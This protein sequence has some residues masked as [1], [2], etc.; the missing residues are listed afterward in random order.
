MQKLLILFILPA[1]I[2][3]CTID[4]KKSVQETMIGIACGE[5]EGK[6]FHGYRL[7][8][9]GVSKFTT[10][11]LDDLDKAQWSKAMD[12]EAERVKKIVSLLP[13]NLE[14]YP[15]RIGCPDCAD[16]C[17]IYIATQTE[18]GVKMIVVDPSS[19][20]KEFTAF[21]EEMKTLQLF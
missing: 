16:Q 18:V 12:F 10:I 17:A 8:T 7:T 14:Q 4:G 15:S 9:A 20:P 21:V 11:Y 5:C 6:C 3:G 13:P 2:S 19:Y 1:M